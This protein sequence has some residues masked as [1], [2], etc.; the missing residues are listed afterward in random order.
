MTTRPLCGRFPV[1]AD[2]AESRVFGQDAESV[3]RHCVLPTTVI[4]VARYRPGELAV[5]VGRPRGVHALVPGIVGIPATSTLSFTKV[6]TPRKKSAPAGTD[7]P[8]TSAW[9]RSNA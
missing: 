9:A 8:A 1:I 2:R 6:G 3:L 5:E 7:G 4:P